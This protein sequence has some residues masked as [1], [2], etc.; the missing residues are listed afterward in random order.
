MKK[1]LVFLLALTMLAGL[2]ACGAKEPEVDISGKY[3][4]TSCMMDGEEYPCDGEYVKLNSDGTGTVMFIDTEYDIDWVLSGSDFSFTDSDG[5]K[6]T[7]TYADGVLEGVYAGMDYV[8]D[9]NG[10]APKKGAAAAAPAA[11][12]EEEPEE[13]PVEEP[14]EEPAAFEPVGSDLGEYY[15]E[16]VGVESFEDHNGDPAIR[17]YYDFTNNSEEVE[18]GSEISVTA[19]QSGFELV[20]TYANYEDDV[21]EYGNDLLNVYPG[22]TIRCIEE[23]SYNPEAGGTITIT[24]EDWWS[25]ETMTVEVDSANLP[26]APA[27]AREI[28]TIAEPT[29]TEGWE[30]EGENGDCYFK[31]LSAEVVDAA[32]YTD[33]DQVIRFYI[34]YTNNSDE[35]GSCWWNSYFYAYQ[36]GIQLETSTAKDENDAD[37]MYS[38]DVEPG[39]TVE[40]AVCYGLRTDSPV[41]L[42][43]VDSW[44]DVYIGLCAEVG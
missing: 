18:S 12:P 20:T 7:G 39:E 4:A 16:L 35:A 31:I 34:E 14:V 37:E 36:D 38:T 19:K 43:L 22:V 27:E 44:N 42:T 28:E 41:E 17:V 29:Y 10:A 40:C 15:V 2:A 8:Y 23:L 3:Y 24:L 21:D 6:F 13:E 5:D 32:G 1:V 11:E 9:M 33:Y 26:G 25:D 30:T